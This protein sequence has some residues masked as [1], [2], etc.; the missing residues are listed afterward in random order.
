MGHFCLFSSFQTNIT[1]ITTNQCEK[2]PSGIW[3][4]DSNPQP[5]EHES[6][7]ITTRPG[8]YLLF[9]Y[10]QLNTLLLNNAL[11][12]LGLNKWHDLQNP[13]TVLYSR[14]EQLLDLVWNMFIAVQCS[15]VDRWAERKN[16]DISLISYLDDL[17]SN[18]SCAVA[19]IAIDYVIA[20]LEIC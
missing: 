19:T 18:L 11:L 8:Q 10:N 14:V 2:W 1:I 7:P 12:Y 5:L 9:R 15:N 3:C 20:F 4:W 13:I 17:G 6:S 16:C